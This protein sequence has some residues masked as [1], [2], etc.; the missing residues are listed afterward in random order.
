MGQTAAARW[1]P[2]LRNNQVWRKWWSKVTAVSTIKLSPQR[3]RIVHPYCSELT[4][5]VQ[6]LL[7]TMF[8]G[9][10][11]L[12]KGSSLCNTHCTTGDTECW[13]LPNFIMCSR[14]HV[15]IQCNAPMS[16]HFRGC[17]YSY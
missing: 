16:I 2:S 1:I 5:T 4:L 3:K 15:C 11:G 17:N 13:F 14:Y 6:V 7:P 8:Q 12:D 10:S 9:R